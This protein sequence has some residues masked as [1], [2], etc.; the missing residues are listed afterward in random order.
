M[1][2]MSINER[3]INMCDEKAIIMTTWTNE[4]WDQWK[5]MSYSREWW[6]WPESVEI[7]IQYSSIINDSEEGVYDQY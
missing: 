7:V 5:G 2:A 3:P 6:K 4:N 1:P